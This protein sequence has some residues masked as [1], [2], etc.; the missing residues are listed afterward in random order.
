MKKTVQVVFLS[1]IAFASSAQGTWT[2]RAAFP[3]AGRLAAAGFS[4]GQKAYVGVGNSPGGYVADFWEYDPATNTW[5]QKANF[6]GGQRGFSFGLSIGNKGYIGTGI[7]NGFIF[8]ND[9]WEYDP[10]TNIWTQKA[11][12]GGGPAATVGGFSIGNFG[13]IG[14]GLDAAFAYQQYFWRFDPAAN[15]WTQLGNFPGAARADID[16]AFFTINGKGYFGTGSDGATAFN[17]LWEY[18]PAT[19]AWTQKANLT[20]PGRYGATGCSICNKGFLGLGVD[21]NT[22]VFYNDWW[23]FDPIAN[24]WSAATAFPLAGRADQPAMAIGNSIFMATGLDAASNYMQDLWEFTLSSGTVTATGTPATCASPNGSATANP[25]GG[26]AP[27]T[28]TWSTTPAQT[29]QTATGL[30]PGTYTVTV[31]DAACMNR[32]TTVTITSGGGFT[33]TM[34]QAN[35]QCFGQN[36]GSATISSAT[37]TAPYTYSWS[38]NP[39]QTGQSIT[40]ISAGN[41]TCSITDATGCLQTATFSITQPTAVTATTSTTPTSC[42]A[43]NGTATASGSGGTAPYTYSWSTIPVQATATAT[44]LGFGTYSVSVTDASGCSATYTASVTLQSSTLTSTASVLNNASCF[45]STDGSATS[46]AS[47]GAGPYSFLWSNGQPTQTS[48]GLAAGNYSVTVTDANGCTIVQPV[49]ITEPTAITLSQTTTTASCGIADGSATVTPSGGSGP[50]SFLWLTSPV[51]TSQTLNNVTTGVYTVL[52]TDANGCTQTMTVNVPGLGPPSSDFLTDHDTVNLLDASIY[53][54]D[55]SNNAYTWLW[56]FGDPLNPS[57]SIQQNPSHVYTDT[58]TYCITLI[59]TDAGG[60]CKDTTV[61]CVRVEAPFTFYVPNAFTPNGDGFNEWF[62]A[63]GTYIKTFEMHVFDRWG[64]HIFESTDI[65][66]GWDGKVKDGTSNTISQQDVYVWKISV[67]DTNN[68]KHNY[69]GH[70]SLVQ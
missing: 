21:P 27:Y 69:I 56:D 22:N 61:K 6:G 15:S 55:L 38:T 57:T 31:T 23:Q 42:T 68:K 32:T 29:T 62:A 45:G 24:S 52:V 20:A 43:N 48:T 7:D 12:F 65:M 58:G 5:T 19:N 4:I 47:G 63:M 1:L 30:A 60:V 2:A 37:G 10:V 59:I 16:R 8:Y 46:T 26:T 51:Q 49:T 9:W 28:Y 3:G 41:Y 53:F 44:G 34:A 66:K 35:V 25:T 33:V 14:T 50:Y 54:T 39:V 13:Y 40:N 64:N 18:D 11:N 36:N 67:T 17:D 70:V